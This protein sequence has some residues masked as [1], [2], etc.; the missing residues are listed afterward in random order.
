MENQ[1]QERI[2]KLLKQNKIKKF[3][4]QVVLLLLIVW[5]FGVLI[6]IPFIAHGTELSS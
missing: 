2:Q 3:N 1:E 5:L 6:S 4:T